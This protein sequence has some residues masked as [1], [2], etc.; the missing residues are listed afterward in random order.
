M[1]TNE[2]RQG[3]GG[4]RGYLMWSLGVSAYAIAVTQRT[5]FGFAGL[6]AAQRFDAPASLVATFVVVQLLTY[7]AAQVPA[8]VLIDRFGSRAMFT[9]GL[10]VMGVGQV[11]LALATS[12]PHG[13]IG[14]IL[15]GAGDAVMF[16]SAVRLVPE[17]LPARSVP[18]FTQMTG[19]LGQVGQIVSAVP[20][21][22]LL[23]TYG[24]E[25]SFLGAAALCWLAAVVVPLLLRDRP[26]GVPRPVPADDE[27]RVRDRILATWRSPGTRLGVWT[28]YASCFPGMV[29]AMMW[30]FPY[31]TRGEGLSA[32]TASALMTLFVLASVPVGP[33]MGTLAARYPFRRSNLVFAGVAANLLPWFVVVV[34]PG[35][36]PMWL[37]I[38]LICGMAVGGPGSNIGFDF[39]RAWNPESRQGT[40]N[41]IVIMGGFVGAL[42]AILAIGLVLDLSTGGGQPGLM[43]FR[44]AMAVQLPMLLLGLVEL[45]RTRAVVRSRLYDEDGIVVRPI[46]TAIRDANRRRRNG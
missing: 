30:G 29:F 3:P 5:T 28:H 42:V 10:V 34:W 36:A 46:T 20:F 39:A 12:L 44:R 38:V 7:A 24:W 15:V 11:S 21:A 13:I 37:L 8:G 18:V 6:E 22:W 43:D 31:L 26:D 41:G 25:P 9:S 4:A 32:P 33:L 27:G 16:G 14:R 23:R 45:R 2:P 1:T 40:A 35:P 17:W 19:I